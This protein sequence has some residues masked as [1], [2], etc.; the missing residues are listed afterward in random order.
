M[1]RGRLVLQCMATIGRYRLRSAFMM[2]GSLLGVAT[3]TLVVS[4]GSGAQRKILAT[5]NQLFGGSSIMVLARGTS[6]IGG[7]RPDG[8]RLTL[9]DLEA[10][11]REVPGVD[12]WDPQQVLAAGPVRRGEASTVAR[13]VGAS[14]RSDR[15]WN[16]AASR[17]TYFDEQAVRASARVALIGTTVSSRLFGDEDPVGGEILAGSVPLKVIGVLES[18][19]TDVHGMDRDNEVVVPISTMMRRL[20]NVDTIALAKV[21]VVDPAATGAAAT[22]VRRVLRARHAIPEGQPDD[23]TLMTAVE[24]ERMVGRTDDILTLYLP[25]VGGVVL[26]VGGLVS[27]ALMLSSVSARTGEIG[28]RRA[29]G[30][31]TADIRLQFLVETAATIVAGGLGGI[32]VAYFGVIAVTRRLQMANLFSW[33]AVLLSLGA[34]ALVGLIAGVAPAR[35]A[36][37]LNPTDALR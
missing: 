1:N 24:V 11:A 32:A 9:D 7:P 14:E 22:E 13:I 27:A 3:L 23:F 37:A 28:L 18:L 15:V 6:L 2:L 26:L 21:I 36:A 20:M 25:L 10:V 12:A 31:R 16:R 33:K 4:V 8:A 34:A 30:A 5:V 35:R 19:G 29:V 17:G